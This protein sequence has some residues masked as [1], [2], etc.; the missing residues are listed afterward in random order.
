MY[1]LRATPPAAGPLCDEP[2]VEL[3]DRQDLQ[4]WQDLKICCCVAKTDAI[5]DLKCVLLTLFSWFF[6]LGTHFLDS[7]SLF[8]RSRGPQGQQRGY[9]RIQG[10]IFIDFWWILGPSFGLVL[11]QFAHFW[12]IWGT[13]I[14]ASVF[15]LLFST[16]LYGFFVEI[17]WSDV[18]KT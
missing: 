11:E 15:R 10:S 13:Q 9:I 16:F 4:N 8:L 18:L 6:T 3:H 2:T 14:P 12:E 5:L 17:W 1:I 7:G